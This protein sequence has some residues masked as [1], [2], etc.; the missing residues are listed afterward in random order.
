MMI[1][2]LCSASTCRQYEKI[3]FAKRQTHTRLRSASSE[4]TKI[5]GT[6]G[7]YNS[8]FQQMLADRGVFPDGYRGLDGSRPPKPTKLDEL[9]HVLPRTRSSLSLSAFSEGAFEEFQETNRRAK[10]E[11]KVMSSVVPIITGAKDNRLETEGKIQFNNL[12]KFAPGLK[13]A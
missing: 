4:G 9:R 6:T 2:V 7:P 10:S 8:Q 12:E 1:A 11:A 3:K 5:S 13:V